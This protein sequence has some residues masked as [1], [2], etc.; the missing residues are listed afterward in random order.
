M[1]GAERRR[2]ASPAAVTAQCSAWPA[3]PATTVYV[4]P[5]PAAAPSREPGVGD[6]VRRRRVVPGAAAAGQDLAR[7]RVAGDRGRGQRA[8]LRRVDRARVGV[9]QVRGAHAAA[10]PC[11]TSATVERVAPG[12]WRSRCRRAATGRSARRC[13]PSR[14]RCTSAC[15]RAARRRSSAGSPRTS[16]GVGET[17]ALVAAVRPCALTRHWIRWPDVRDGVDALARRWRPPRRRAATRTR[18]RRRRPRCP[19]RTSARGRAAGRRSRAGRTGSRGRATAAGRLSAAVTPP[20][21]TRQAARGRRRGVPPGRSRRSRGRSARRRAASRRWWRTAAPSS[22]SQSPRVQVATPPTRRS[23][24]TAGRTRLRGAV[25]ERGRAVRGGHSRGGHDAGHAEVEVGGGDDVGRRLRALD[26]L[27]VA[28][29]RERRRVRRQPAVVP[30]AARAAQLAA[31]PR[32]AAE[33][34]PRAVLG[35]A[36]ERSARWTVPARAIGDRDDLAE[37]A[38]ARRPRR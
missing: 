28:Q 6:G 19:D 36:H 8:R 16:G 30:D 14:R 1:T 22:S 25:R 33:L 4:A 3:S 34:R 21:V 7:A 26:R 35:V 31:E 17:P 18:A 38:S 24:P 13:R 12:R 11:A 2:V 37:R 5:V 15:A 29:P 27:V 10:E 23:P 9:G 20:A 32:R